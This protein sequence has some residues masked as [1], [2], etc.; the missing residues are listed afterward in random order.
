MAKKTPE[1]RALET[2][3]DA[4]LTRLEKGEGTQED[5]DAWRS[6]LIGAPDAWRVAGDMAKHTAREMIREAAGK[7]QA[8]HEAM[9]QGYREIKAGL[10][11]ETSPMLEKLLID[12]IVL[13]WLRWTL[14]E[15][16]YS[17]NTG[18]SPTITQADYWDRH[19]N[20]TQRRYVRAIEALA[21]VRKMD[22]PPLQIN[23]GGQQVN[24]AGKG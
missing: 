10:G 1:T 7:N 20:A 16:W 4:R 22:L 24:I 14:T 13:C 19:L 5:I 11:Y 3:A 8:V 18:D 23:I 9:K 17:K 6:A 2:I 12:A 15:Y 21:R